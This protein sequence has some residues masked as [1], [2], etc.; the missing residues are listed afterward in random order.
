MKKSILLSLAVL[1]ISLACLCDLPFT[2]IERISSTLDETEVASNSSP[3]ACSGDDCLDA[4][5]V[6]INKVL[7]P[8]NADLYVAQGDLYESY[9]LAS[10]LVYD[11]ELG[12][13]NTYNVPDNLLEIQEDYSTQERIWEY[14][15][16][17]LP[18]EDL[19]M[20]NQY[21]VYTDGSDNELAYV[22]YDDKQG[23]TKWMLAVDVVDANQPVQL[24]HTLV[25]EFG[26]LITLNADQIPEGSDY[27]GWDQEESGCDTF[28]YY[29]GCTNEDS[30]INLFYEAFWVDIFPDWKRI[31]GDPS[32]EL[33]DYD[34]D[35]VAEFYEMYPDQFV[36]DYAPTEIGEDIAESFE[37][38]VLKT[39]PDGDSIAEQKILFFYQFP[40]LVELREQ[41]IQAI[42]DF[43]G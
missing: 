41:M 27:W 9:D 31:V 24:T 15:S 36:D 19:R 39:K 25:H 7:K 43:E 8:E 13:V 35:A 16:S 11:G 22:Y 21:L 33:E 2:V 29:Y 40:E 14:A 18:A 4:C 37:F 32:E 20:I 26:H 3:S 5:L 34:E 28:T 23:R 42:C 12:R 10:Y 38:F 6:R 17:L 30:Y 1:V